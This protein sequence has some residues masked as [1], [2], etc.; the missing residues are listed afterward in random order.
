M[1][2]CAS[3]FSKDGMS[4]PCGK[5]YDCKMR[6]VSGW[7]FRL[8]KEAEISSSALFVT[9]TYNNETVPLTANGFM[10]LRKRDVQLFFKM[11]RYVANGRVRGASKLTQHNPIKYYTVG[12]YGGKTKRPH[13]H[14]IIFNATFEDVLASWPHGDC[15]C[16]ELSPASA[17][18]T[19]KYISKDT[20]VGTFGRDDRVPE[21]SLMSKGL[22]KNYLTPAMKRWHKNDLLNRYYIPLKDGKKIA[23]PRYYKERLYSKHQRQR[24]GTSLVEKNYSRWNSM[25][26]ENKLAEMKKEDNLRIAKAQRNL[27]DRKTSL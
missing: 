17:S 13:Y 26:Y 6:R 5:C 4:F 16:G 18:Y 21:F 3:P 2:E 24:I 25:T 11:L 8:Q 22:G 1:A 23:M 27:D 7:S 19:L 9:M 12:E 10:T 20:K 14:A 15:H